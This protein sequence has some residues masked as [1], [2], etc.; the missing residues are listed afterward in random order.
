MK[1][2]ISILLILMIN[3]TFCQEIKVKKDIIIIDGKEIAMIK[4]I[5]VKKVIDNVKGIYEFYDLN[6]SKLFTLYYKNQ[7]VNK[8]LKE[9]V[10]LIKDGNPNENEVDLKSDIFSLNFKRIFADFLTKKYN[11]FNSNGINYDK[12]NEFFNQKI[13]SGEQ[14]LVESDSNKEKEFFTEGYFVQT[15]NSNNIDILSIKDKKL[16]LG[17]FI[18]TG[19]KCFNEQLNSN[20]DYAS[21]IDNDKNVVAKVICNGGVVIKTIKNE[22]IDSKIST[23]NLDLSLDT[24]INKILL[25]LYKKNYTLGNQINKEKVAIQNDKNKVIQ[26]QEK[27]KQLTLDEAKVN[28]KNIYYQPGYIITQ[29][30]EKI[31]GDI[32]IDF[33]DIDY[34]VTHNGESN[35][36]LMS[37]EVRLKQ[38]AKFYTYKATEGVKF[39]INDKKTGN[40]KCYK[41]V[42]YK[43]PLINANQYFEIAYENNN[44]YIFTNPINDYVLIQPKDKEKAFLL[45]PNKSFGSGKQSLEKVIPDFDK[46]INCT[47]INFKNYDINSIESL[48]S[49]LN[50]YHSKCNK[51]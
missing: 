49:M 24:D 20:I 36:M 39:C 50:D 6:N 46:Y 27:Q 26:E 31:S 3:I 21:I 12:I 33:E 29:K 25:E 5:P 30:N 48:K 19:N 22:V 10:K 42:K 15:G 17:Q 37:Y 45:N 28:S 32:S 51:K 2:I 14:K 44:D 23:L 35:K 9:W 47:E 4:E 8:S 34:I 18:K 16:V 43:I 13:E 7:D 38:P 11:F 40:E 41:G 1:Q